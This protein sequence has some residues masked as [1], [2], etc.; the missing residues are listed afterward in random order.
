[1]PD[2]DAVRTSPVPRVDANNRMTSHAL[3]HGVWRVTARHGFMEA[4]D[5]PAFL[6]LLAYREGQQIEAM[7]TSYFTSRASVGTGK[8]VGLGSL[9]KAVFAWMQRN[10]ARAPDY[11]GLPG[12]RLIEIGRRA[13]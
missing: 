4:P 2:D 10:A 8:L 5:V 6:K 1:M 11:F 3:G 12:N 7:A 9:R 13:T